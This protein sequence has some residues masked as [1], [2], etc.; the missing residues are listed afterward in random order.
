MYDTAGINATGGLSL[1]SLATPSLFAE[2]LQVTLE[3]RR[4]RSQDSAAQKVDARAKREH[5]ND[6]GPGLARHD[7]TTPNSAR[8]D[9]SFARTPATERVVSGSEQVLPVTGSRKSTM[10]S[11]R[12]IHCAPATSMMRSQFRETGEFGRLCGAV[13]VNTLTLAVR[14]SLVFKH[15]RASILT[16]S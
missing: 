3:L 9:F 14:G 13:M 2:P 1:C 12:P 7:G 11:Q 8:L 6:A 5:E 4:A 15:L 10:P 16:G